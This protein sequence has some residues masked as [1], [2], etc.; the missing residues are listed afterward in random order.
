MFWKR[1]AS[2]AR[3]EAPPVVRCSFCNKSARDVEM[4]IAGPK[5]NI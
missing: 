1:K 2:E 3:A 5:V 4:M